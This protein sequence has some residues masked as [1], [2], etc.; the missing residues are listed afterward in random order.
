MGEKKK[1]GYLDQLSHVL[2]AKK[3]TG[4]GGNGGGGGQVKRLCQV[5]SPQVSQAVRDLLAGRGKR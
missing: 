3:T 5:L 1:L 2:E 4:V